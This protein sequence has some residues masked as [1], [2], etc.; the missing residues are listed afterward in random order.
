MMKRMVQSA[1]VLAAL[2]FAA[3]VFS[4]PQIMCGS[5]EI[6][7]GDSVDTVKQACG[8]PDDVKQLDKLGFTGLKY[9]DSASK[10]KFRFGFMGGKLIHFSVTSAEMEG[11]LKMLKQHMKMKMQQHMNNGTTPSNGAMPSTTTPTTPAPTTAP[12]Q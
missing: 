3:P 4:A 12:S 8:N 6:K 2:A 5:T 10:A 9:N 1:M 7:I 11:K